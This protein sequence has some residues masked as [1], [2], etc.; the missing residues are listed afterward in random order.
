MDRQ[1]TQNRQHDVEEQKVG[2]LMLPNPKTYYKT[3]VIKT[4]W[5]WQKN[6]QIG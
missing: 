3:T 2:G 4:V 6:R 5:N 1:K